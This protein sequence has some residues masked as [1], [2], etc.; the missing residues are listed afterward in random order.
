MA[1]QKNR[2]PRYAK[3]FSEAYVFDVSSGD[4][5]LYSNKF[6]TGNITTSMNN[7]AIEG[8]LGN[9]LLL[10]IPDTTRVTG[11]FET[12]DFSLEARGL[13][14]GST[15]Q[16]NGVS[17]IR[18]RIVATTTTLTVSKTPA[19]AYGQASSE[20]VYNCYVGNDG[21][22]YGVDKTTKEVQD[23]TATPGQEY[24]VLYY[25]AVLSAESLAVPTSFAPVIGSMVIKTPIYSENGNSAMN[26][27]LAGYLYNFY[28]RAQFIGGDAGI[29][30]S[31]TEAT[32]TSWNFE[33]LA[34]DEA[35]ETCSECANDNS[36]YGYMV[37]VPCNQ[38][39]TLS[40]VKGLA[41]VGGVIALSADTNASNHTAQLPVFYYM[42]NGQLITPT[43]TDLTYTSD[44]A[45]V[46][47]SNSGL[48]TA[49][50]ANNDVHVTA[51]ATAKPSL[52]ATVTVSVA[53]ATGD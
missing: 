47:V 26:S 30:G 1:Y 40:A 14:M 12:A 7:G 8:G 11:S 41:I 13:Q 3:G 49:V 32:T 31:Q 27:S 23:F 36:V 43:Y 45:A 28:P 53:A 15:V 38:R 42:D 46:T 34:Y 48:L 39:D 9:R 29:N 20:Q 33:V 10:N 37:Y 24:C 2:A 19:S 16:Y 17:L 25:S 6:K 44:N 50:S 51:T 18:E 4:L 22:N 52:T 5:L 35:D 21:V